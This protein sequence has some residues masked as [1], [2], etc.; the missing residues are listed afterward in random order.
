MAR[1][2][3]E[4]AD[5]FSDIEVDAPTLRLIANAIR[6]GMTLDAVA[7]YSE[8]AQFEQAELVAASIDRLV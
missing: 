1:I 6:A 3:I 2:L 7:A 4:T 8:Y 5:D